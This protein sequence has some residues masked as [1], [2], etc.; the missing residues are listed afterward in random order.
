M[1]GDN[2]ALAPHGAE[3]IA[4]ARVLFLDGMETKM[5]KSQTHC[6]FG[7]KAKLLLGRINVA[8]QVIKHFTG[9]RLESCC[10]RET[11]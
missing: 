10:L 3:I 1:M 8:L 4:R 11:Q 2:L 6:S 5:K 9:F 7:V